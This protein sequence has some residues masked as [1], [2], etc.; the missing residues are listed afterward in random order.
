[1]SPTDTIAAVASGWGHSHW[2]LIRLSGPQ[3]PDLVRSLVIPGA[4][5]PGAAAW[6]VR[7]ADF[8]LSDRH[9]LPC[10]LMTY[11]APRSFTG[12]PVA[13]LL[14]PGNPIILERVM[15]RLTEHPGVR[16][17]E[18]GEFS[19]RAYLNGKLTLEQAEGLAAAIA[20]GSAAQLAEA[21]A[22]RSGQT[23]A[24]R[25]A[26]CDRL[27]ALLALVEAGID[28]TDQEDVVPIAPVRLSAGLQDLLDEVTASLGGRRGEEH[29]RHLPRVALVGPPNAGKST[30]FNALLGRRRAIESPVAGATR[31]VIAEPMT[32]DRPDRVVE[33][34]D[35]P[36]LDAGLANRSE[37]DRASQEH[38]RQAIDT[39]DVLI[40]CR[41]P[42]PRGT[43]D[44]ARVSGDAASPPVP[45]RPGQPVIRVRTM[46]DLPESGPSDTSVSVC[47]LDG[48][49]LDVLRRAIADAIFQSADA[50]GA[51]VFLLPRHRRAL[52]ESAAHLRAALEVIDPGARALA[53]PEMVAGEMRLALDAL[54]ELTG[55]I[56]P[57]DIIGRVF[58]TFCIGK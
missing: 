18:P 57:D 25:R 47:A 56:S 19:A 17:A 7:A 28:F 55:Q 29:A 16:E 58:A 22:L 34:L 42:R 35:L 31:D 4:A 14:V 27:A 33:L 49:N 32:L 37:I 39:A 54:A 9:A 12:E 2:G 1:M 38:A 30:L 44:R 8:R 10:R 45:H 46:A 20:A 5:D 52:A 43:G 41:P 51:G 3:T 21:E 50:S 13:E 11:A 36:G 48:W 26:W 15:A 24:R 23:G 6:S 53:N 40:E